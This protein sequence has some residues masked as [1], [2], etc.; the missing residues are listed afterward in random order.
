MKYNCA[1]CYN[2]CNELAKLKK[3]VKKKAE[4]VCRL[5]MCQYSMPI[6]ENLCRCPA[7]D[8]PEWK[9]VTKQTYWQAKQPS[10]LAWVS[11]DLKCWGAWNIPSITWRREVWKE[12]AFDDLL[13]RI[14]KGH[15]Q[16]D[17]HWTVSKATLGKLLRDGLIWARRRHSW[18]ELN[19]RNWSGTTVAY[20]IILWAHPLIRP[21][22]GVHVAISEAIHEAVL[23]PLSR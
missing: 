1:A 18:T 11:K 23:S 2:L 17:Q 8:M 13:E 20:R 12:E 6:F 22:V 10:Q 5:V 16:L 3:Y 21:C 9:E 4:W 15:H 14:W 19:Q 7:L